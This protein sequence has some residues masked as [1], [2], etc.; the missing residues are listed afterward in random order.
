[1][2][3]IVKEINAEGQ[4][5]EKVY[6][7]LTDYDLSSWTKDLKDDYTRTSQQRTGTPPYMAQELLK[8]TSASHLYRHDVESLFYIML[9]MCGRHDIVDVKDEVTKK[10]V[11]RRVAMRQ[12]LLPYE[13]WF[14]EPNYERLGKMKREFLM[15]DQPTIYLTESF[16]DF[17]LWLKGILISFSEGFESKLSYNRKQWTSGNDTGS[18]PFDDET[19]GNHVG[20]STMINSIPRLKGELEGLI[21]RYNPR[22]EGLNPLQ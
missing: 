13:D 14:N 12:G 19:L 21:I 4:Q 2:C 5:E 16:K 18:T 17:H 1:M 8:G 15:D 6:G 7:V 3:R 10:A 22:L 11:T 20:Y 9:L